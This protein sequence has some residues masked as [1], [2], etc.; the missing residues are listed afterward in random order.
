VTGEEALR[1]CCVLSPPGWQRVHDLLEPFLI[2]GEGT[3]FQYLTEAGGI[4]WIIST[5]R[6]W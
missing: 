2:V 5:T 3:R 6:G 4:D 1:F